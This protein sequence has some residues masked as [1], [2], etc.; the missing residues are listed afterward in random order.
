MVGLKI[1]FYKLCNYNIHVLQLLNLKKKKIYCNL[2]VYNINIYITAIN[3]STSEYIVAA[4]YYN[5]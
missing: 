1:L 3:M 4:I 5:I 2:Y